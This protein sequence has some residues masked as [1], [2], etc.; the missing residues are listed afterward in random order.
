[1][2]LNALGEADNAN[3]LVFTVSLTILLLG[4]VVALLLVHKQRARRLN[5]YEKNLLEIAT[6]PPNYV[7]CKPISRLDTEDE[8]PAEQRSA[9]N[10]LKPLRKQSRIQEIYRHSCAQDFARLNRLKR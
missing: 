3:V 2:L 9:S 1:M 8:P 6:S 4:V 5:W 7:R 10:R